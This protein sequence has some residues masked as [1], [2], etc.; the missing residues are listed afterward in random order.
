MK[1]MDNMIEIGRFLW[2]K[3]IFYVPR[4]VIDAIRRL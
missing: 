1:N 2:E 4:I 3:F